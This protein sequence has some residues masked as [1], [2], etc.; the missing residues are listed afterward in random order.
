MSTPAPEAQRARL[1]PALRARPR[2]LSSIVFGLLV[3]VSVDRLAHLSG[4]AESLIAWNAGALLNLLLTWHMAR[5]T[6][7][8]MI[9]R[10]ALTQGEGRVAILTVVVLAAVAV[11]VAVGT[12]LSQVKNLEGTPRVLHVLLA[13]ATVASSWLFTQSVF[14]QHYAHDFYLARVRGAPDPL[15]FPGTNDPL[16]ADFFH[17]A[18]VIGTSGQT[19]DISFNGSA[20]RPVGTVHCI[21]AFFFNASLLALSINVAAGMIL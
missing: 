2:L 14:A 13:V 11:L 3:Y 10:R 17:F 5:H 21:V 8:D 7:V 4:A 12:Q 15:S 20:L 16:Y 19:A 6:D 1:W 9:R 18:C